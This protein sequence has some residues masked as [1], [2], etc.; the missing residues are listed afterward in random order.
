MITL[1]G[2]DDDIGEK[3]LNWAGLDKIWHENNLNNNHSPIYD[4]LY[5]CHSLDFEKE[6]FDADR[7]MASG[8]FFKVSIHNEQAAKKE[9]ARLV[10]E[11]IA[12]GD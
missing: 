6:E 9:L 8:I 1:S 3:L 4:L 11:L 7:P 10:E 2:D 12:K 5:V